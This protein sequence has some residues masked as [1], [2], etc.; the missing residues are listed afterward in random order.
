MF[1]LLRSFRRKGV[2]GMQVCFVLGVTTMVVLG[3]ISTLG[4]F[5]STE[6]MDTAGRIADPSTLP[7][8]FSKNYGS[9]S[10]ND[11]DGASGSHQDSDD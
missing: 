6:M 2:S 4:T 11:A 3:S 1:H 8:K 9:C 7:A 10:Q 5:T